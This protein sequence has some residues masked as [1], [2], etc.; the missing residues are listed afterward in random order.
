[1]SWLP[2]FSRGVAYA[3]AT[4]AAWGLDLNGLAMGNTRVGRALLAE[5][6]PEQAEAEVRDD[7]RAELKK[8]A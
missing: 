6:Y 5:Y 1:M 8:A 3:F 7:K 2:K 4:G